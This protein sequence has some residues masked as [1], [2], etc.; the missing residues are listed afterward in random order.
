MACQKKKLY[1]QGL[2][3]IYKALSLNLFTLQL[4]SG[5]KKMQG[6]G[7]VYLPSFLDHPYLVCILFGHANPLHLFTFLKYVFFFL[8]IYISFEHIC[9]KVICHL[10]K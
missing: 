1:K 5:V 4:Y 6:W 8:R 2:R 7:F 3:K 9:D 10:L